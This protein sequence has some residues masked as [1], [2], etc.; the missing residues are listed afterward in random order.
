M[1]PAVAVAPLPRLPAAAPVAWGARLAVVGADWPLKEE[2]TLAE[3][4]PFRDQ[5]NPLRDHKNLFRDQDSPFRGQG[6]GAA[7]PESS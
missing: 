1:A 3:C 7:A 2:R 5:D 4:D 6:M